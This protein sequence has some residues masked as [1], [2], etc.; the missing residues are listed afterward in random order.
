MPCERLTCL[1]GLRGSARYGILFFVQT[2]SISSL[3]ASLRELSKTRTSVSD[4]F[5]FAIR[6]SQSKAHGCS[7]AITSATFCAARCRLLFRNALSCF[8]RI[9][10]YIAS[11]A[12][13]RACLSACWIGTNLSHS[14]KENSVRLRMNR[15]HEISSESNHCAI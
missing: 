9:V 12:S 5:L 1:V 7:N 6:N 15:R 14:V 8:G 11:H 4:K 3:L 10:L 2:R 13:L